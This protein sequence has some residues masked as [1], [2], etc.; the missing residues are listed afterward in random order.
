ML[1]Q[2]TNTN[3]TVSTVTKEPLHVAASNRHE[4]G[5]YR[6]YQH[7]HQTNMYWALV[8]VTKKLE[9]SLVYAARIRSVSTVSK[10]NR[11]HKIQKRKQIFWILRVLDL[12]HYLAEIT[13]KQ[14]KSWILRVL[15]YFQKWKE[16]E[17]MERVGERIRL[18]FFKMLF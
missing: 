2:L 3:W 5:E 8:T 14:P 9:H 1:R 11:K 10:L 18:R 7:R 17:S 12:S 16:R 15:D 6:Q 13:C 4:F